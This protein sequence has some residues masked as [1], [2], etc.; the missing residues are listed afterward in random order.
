MELLEREVRK[1]KD[2]AWVETKMVK[3]IID[4]DQDI[5]ITKNNQTLLKHEAILK[6]AE[7]VGAVW[8]EPRREDTPSS[9]NDKGFYYLVT[10]KFPDGTSNFESGEAND[11]NTEKNTIS[12][13]YKQSV[14]IKRGMDR[15][16]LKSSYMKMYDVY[17]AEEVDS[18]KADQLKELETQNELLRSELQTKSRLAQ[19][20]V[21][22]I[23]LDDEDTK[24]PNLR[25]VDI[26]NIHRDEAYMEE[27]NLHP[28]RVISWVARGLLQKIKSIREKEDE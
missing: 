25:L 15:S 6:L 1:M 7:Y 16:F 11:L 17:S 5:W 19:Q 8:E 10:C 28:D 14:A 24:Y 20:M 26:W 21:E 9:T 23:T 2:G 27:L 22:S 13:R 18:L 3:E 12:Q 4:T